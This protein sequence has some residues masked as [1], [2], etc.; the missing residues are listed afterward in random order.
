MRTHHDQIRVP[1]L[2]LTDNVI[3][4]AISEALELRGVC[5]DIALADQR[6]SVGDYLLAFGLQGIDQLAD[7]QPGPIDA[8]TLNDNGLLDHIDEPQSRSLVLGQAEK[9]TLP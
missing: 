4:T 9:T 3:R 5:F 7:I 6:H 1:L 8:S 2:R